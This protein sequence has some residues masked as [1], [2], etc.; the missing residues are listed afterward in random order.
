MGEQC[1]SA[2]DRLPLTKRIVKRVKYLYESEL[3]TDENKVLVTCEIIFFGGWCPCK[4][5]QIPL[6]PSKPE[7]S[8][9]D[10]FQN[11]IDFTKNPDISNNQRHIEDSGGHRYGMTQDELND[12]LEK[13]KK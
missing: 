4:T 2:V 12:L 11:N 8:L 1:A 13:N 6:K 3:K 5:Q 10:M 7:V 9:K